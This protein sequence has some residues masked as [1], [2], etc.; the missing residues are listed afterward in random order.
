MR[1]ERESNQRSKMKWQQ[2]FSRPGKQKA[3]RNKEED[4]MGKFGKAG[5]TLGCFVF[6]F[7]LGCEEIGSVDSDD[8]DQV[9]RVASTGHT[10]NNL[11]PGGQLATNQYL[12]SKDGSHRL[13]LQSDGNL[14]LKRMSDGKSLWSSGTGGKSATRLQLQKD[15][16]LVLRTASG[17]A[18]W[19]TKTAGSGATKLYLHSAGQLVLYRDSK[20]VWS[21]NGTASEP[22]EQPD[23]PSGTDGKITHVGTNSVWDG[24]G[25]NIR[26]AR[27]SG[28]KAGDLLVLILHRT[29]DDL[30]LYV[31]GWTRVAECYKGDN[32][33]ACS[34]EATCKSWHNDDFCGDFGGHGGHDLAQSIF[35]RKAS[36]SEPSSY[37]FNLNRDSSGHPGWIIL[38]ALRGAATS[39][40]VR[41]WAHMGC[42]GSSRSVFPSV[43]GVAGDMVLLSQ[44]FDD[45]VAQSKFGAP[46]G[47]KTFG[48]VSNSDEAGFLFGGTLNKT[49][50][51][52]KMTTT[53]DGASSCKDALVSLTIKPQ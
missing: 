7:A 29:D 28:S 46:S 25:Q 44:S 10:S 1:L 8:L 4:V 23:E 19:S 18:V 42:D 40:P 33:Y 49:G 12:G 15:G 27:P 17:K 47:T 52:G 41:D 16:N 3:T 45:K 22:D 53:G 5:F 30:P 43:Y 50:E 2:V 39:N 35:Y 36:S 13:Y 24:D 31:N 38:S 32:G 11:L 20:V 26:I 21:V 34:T 14:M 51:T 6:L 9:E 37:T 48:Y